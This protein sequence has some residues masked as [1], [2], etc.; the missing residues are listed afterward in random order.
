MRDYLLLLFETHEFILPFNEFPKEKINECRLV[1]QHFYPEHDD[2]KR[3]DTFRE[4]K[5]LMKSITHQKRQ[6]IR[7]KIENVYCYGIS[8]AGFEFYY[9]LGASDDCAF[10]WL[11]DERLETVFINE[12][13]VPILCKDF[14]FIILVTKNSGEKFSIRKLFGDGS[15]TNLPV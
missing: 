5:Y 4:A 1:L 11:C 13:S 12:I 8:N 9:K 6:E 15:I 2:R 14:E 10:S 7:K 3:F